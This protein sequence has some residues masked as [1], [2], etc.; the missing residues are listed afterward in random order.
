MSGS[1]STKRS[2]S[3]DSGGLPCLEVGNSIRKPVGRRRIA[4]FQK[5]KRWIVQLYAA[6]V[7]E[8]VTA[9]HDSSI[10][11]RADHCFWPSTTA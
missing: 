11:L 2:S 10:V 1:A 4:L 8:N 9:G 6:T 5:A 7:S 3:Y